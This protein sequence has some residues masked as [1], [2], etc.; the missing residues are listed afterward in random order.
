MIGFVLRRLAVAIPLV[1]VVA[2]ISFFLIQLVP[3]S[4]AAAILGNNA[5][6]AQVTALNHQLGLDR[7]VLTEYF[8]WLGHAVQGNL[9]V[10][11]INAGE[12]VTSELSQ[13]LPPTLSLALLATL[14]TL[15]LGT[16]L[17]TAAAVRGGLTDRAVQWGS[18]L[19]M[20]VP[21][22]WLAALLV[23]VFALKLPLLPATGYVDLTASPGQWL[24]HL[25]LPVV[26]LSVANIGQIAF[27][28][29]AAVQDTLSR[30]FVR[31]LH[32]TG[33][34]RWR[35]IYKHTLRN[36]AIPVVTVTGLTFIFM[37]GG[38]VILEQLFTL[39][40]MGELMLRSVQTHDFSTV[41]GAVL[42]FSIVV[43]VV[44]LVVD[45]A[46]AALD[47]RVRIR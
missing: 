18:S 31:T 5:T 6:G 33:V 34:P 44:N 7:P 13:A 39:P 29:R 37:L 17:G 22:F 27:Q 42:Y 16:V 12:P 35:I 19:G 24:S 41:Q 47:P 43:I 38:V 4:P 2:T 23:F 32:S 9:G 45:L 26:A 14:I 30:D 36:A 15:V 46:T 21:N 40:G 1:V 11:Y 10:S 28:A 8:T 25:I 3:G 20:A